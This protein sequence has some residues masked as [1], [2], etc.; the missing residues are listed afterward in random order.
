MVK[1]ALKKLASITMMVAL[2]TTPVQ[3]TTEGNLTCRCFERYAEGTYAYYGSGYH[4]IAIKVRY[5]YKVAG[6]DSFSIDN[7]NLTHEN[8]TVIYAATQP[9]TGNKFSHYGMGFGYVDNELK[10]QVTSY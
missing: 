3:A 5:V 1:N 9:Y 10:S 8:N 7:S 4:T 6:G 2:S